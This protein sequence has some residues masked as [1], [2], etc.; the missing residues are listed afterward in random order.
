MRKLILLIVASLI[1][2]A[3]A[4]LAQSGDGR[5]RV[6]DLASEAVEEIIVTAR[7][8]EENLKDIPLSA[9]VFGESLIREL[10]IQDLFDVQFQSPNVLIAPFPAVGADA[11]ISMR[12]QSQF[13]PVITLDPAVGMY[14]DGVYLGRSTGALLNLLDLERIE[15]LMGPQ[16]TL[17]GRNTTGGIIHLISKKNV[18]GSFGGNVSALVGDTGRAGVSASVSFPL[19]GDSV[20]GR[21]SLLSTRRDGFGK[22]L[23]L[24]EDLD[25]EDATAW[26]LNLNWAPSENVDILLSL[27][28]T[29]QRERSSLFHVNHIDP[30]VL[31]PDCLMQAVPPL[32]CFVNF[33]ITGGQW[34]GVLDADPRDVRSDVSSLHALDVIGAAATVELD[35]DNYTFTSITAYRELDRRN[36]NDI[37]GTEW[38]ILHPDADAGQQQASQEF[39]LHID[40][41]DGGPEWVAGVF[42]FDESGNDDTTVIGVPALNPF[43]PNT[44]LP[45]GENSSWALFG[46]MTYSIGSQTTLGAGARYTEEDRKLSAQQFNAAGCSLEFVNR[47]PCTTEVE[48]EFDGV[49]YTLSLDHKL[50][51]DSMVYASTSR[52]F[53]SGGFNARATKEIEFDPFDPEIVTS[54]EMGWKTSRAAAGYEAS[55]AAFYDDYQEI[56]RS[57]LIALSPTDIA[58]AVDNAADAYVTGA[59]IRVSAYPLPE[60]TLDASVGL[61]I[62]RYREYQDTDAMGNAIDKSGLEFP[63]TPRWNFSTRLNYT[64]PVQFSGVA[65]A[66]ASYSWRS[67][68]Y[69]DVDNSPWLT[70]GAYGLLDL[71]F[72]V[73]WPRTK[74]EVSVVGKNVLDKLYLTDGLDLVNQFG[75]SGVFLGPPRSYYAE[76]AWHFDSL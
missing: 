29:R 36:I 34:S 4:A 31:N 21:F 46:H 47:Q 7:R 15:V 65:S 56:Q 2:P 30:A 61:T 33:A 38:A 24:A 43:S 25:D 69:S 71:R 23:L 50:S 32:G 12:G 66:Q 45:R 41:D 40:R 8:R 14:V 51:A 6:A 35:L 20:S 37:D 16:G 5:S 74:I 48:E 67:E 63:K 70:Q 42:L 58:T 55:I 28:S 10:A 62:A 3:G 75:Y 9:S 13:E 27:D 22:N 17:Y 52:G 64:L 60:L 73:Y 57:R 44:I 49:S 18:D 11:S 54:F 72:N 26:R 59:E 68:T 19:V 1:S 76:I 53:K 39:Q